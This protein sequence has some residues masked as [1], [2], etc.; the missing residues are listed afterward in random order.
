MKSNNQPCLLTPV[1]LIPS[2][3]E[4]QSM[5]ITNELLLKATQAFHS[6]RVQHK[7]FII[8]FNQ[9]FIKIEFTPPCVL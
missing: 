1:Q 2:S 7:N 5:Q 6:H 3:S 8:E 9:V 4:L